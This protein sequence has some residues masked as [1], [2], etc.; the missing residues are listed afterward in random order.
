MENKKEKIVF[1]GCS[2]N[3]NWKS[4]LGTGVLLAI[5][6]FVNTP[7]L[8]RSYKY[9]LKFQAFI[10]EYQEGRTSRRRDSEPVNPTLL[11]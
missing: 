6:Q 7:N 5:C 10:W 9:F 4:D 2:S 8:T 11:L 3:S 1:G